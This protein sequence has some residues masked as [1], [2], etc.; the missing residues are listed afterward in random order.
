[1]AIDKA[2]NADELF[3]FTLDLFIIEDCHNDAILPIN[4][5]SIIGICARVIGF[6]ANLM[7]PKQIKRGANAP[8]FTSI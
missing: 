4:G 5:Y 7:L 8:R 3:I 2:Y 6:P 1:M